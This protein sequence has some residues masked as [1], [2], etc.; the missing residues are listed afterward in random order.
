MGSSCNES[1]AEQ[2][3]LIIAIAIIATIVAVLG[4]DK[5]QHTLVVSLAGFAVLPGFLLGLY[6]LFSAAHLKYKSNGAVGQMPI[7][8]KLRRWCYDSGINSFW[9]M[10]LLITLMIVAAFSGWDGKS[11]NLLDFW[12]SFIVSFAVLLN[13]MLVSYFVAEKEKTPT[14]VGK[15]R[16]KQR[17]FWRKK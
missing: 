10:F 2:P 11:E 12:P 5:N 15:K 14:S 4:L 8:E 17:V 13:I 6:I 3:R 1:T 9:A 16:R 7:P